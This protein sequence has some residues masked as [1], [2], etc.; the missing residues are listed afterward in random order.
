MFFTVY[1]PTYNRADLLH[2][3]YDSLMTQ[4]D[5]D[6]EWLIIDDGSTDHTE[7]IVEHWA[8][9]APFPV[10]YV[11]QANQGKHFATRYRASDA[12]SS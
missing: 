11:R 10:R 2:R 7:A 6:F 5:R 8:A 9:K 3:V 1:T 12:T 4:D